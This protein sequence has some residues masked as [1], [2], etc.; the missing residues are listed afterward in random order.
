MNKK[1][2]KIEG[3]GPVTDN[4]IVNE[5]SKTEQLALFKAQNTGPTRK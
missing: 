3:R 5:N 4:K 2:L 1:H